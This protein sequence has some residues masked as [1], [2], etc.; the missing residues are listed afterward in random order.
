VKRY[1]VALLLS[2]YTGVA[3][4]GFDQGYMALKQGR[5]QSAYEEWSGAAAQGD[6]GA[7]FGLGVMYDQ[8]WA[9][10]RDQAQSLHWYLKAAEQGNAPAQFHLGVLYYTGHEV[11]RDY[12]EAAR[13]VQKAARQGYGK[14]QY[15]LGC[16]YY[17]GHGVAQD[18]AQA[19]Q[20]FHEAARQ[21]VADAQ[22]DLGGMYAT[23]Q[24]VQQDPLLAFAYFNLAAEAGDSQAAGYLEQIRKTLSPA[25]LADAQ[26]RSAAWRVGRPLPDAGGTSSD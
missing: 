19:V 20:W 11:P 18:Y 15:G 21:G 25:Q 2:L 3:W 9:V 22:V 6:V 7:Q 17:E 8:G 4:C 26:S 14:A 23:G 5:L 1:A 24:G 10:K 16:L 13:W 12:A